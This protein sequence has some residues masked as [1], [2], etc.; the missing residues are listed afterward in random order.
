[1]FCA[2]ADVSMKAHALDTTN[3]HAVVD[4]AG[5]LVRNVCDLLLTHFV[6]IILTYFGQLF[7]IIANMVRA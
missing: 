2:V 3:A 6:Y 5:H 1:M 4:G 7:A